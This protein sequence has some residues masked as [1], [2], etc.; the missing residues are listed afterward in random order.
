MLSLA[1]IALSLGAAAWIVDIGDS[2]P[3]ASAALPPANSLSFNER[4]TSLSG[5]QPARD[6]GLRPLER[7]ALNAVQ[8]KLRDARA[9]LAQ[10]L[11][12]GDWRSTLTD[13]DP[14]VADD[15]APSQRADAVPMPRSRPVQADLAA[16]V[17]SSQAYAETT[18]KVD[19]RSFFE[20]FTD[21]IKLASLTP[22]S[23]LFRKGPDL[24]ALGY[25]SRTAVYDISAKALYLPSGVTL[26]AHSGMGALMD[27]PDHVDQRMVGAT[28]PATYDLKPREKLFHGIRALRMTPAEGTTA[29]GRVGL[30]T[31]S[32]MLGPRGDSNG[33]VSI[34]D[35]DRFLKAYDNGEFNRLVVVPSLKGSA[36][37]S[38]RAT[39]DS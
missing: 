37:A 14:A 2:A 35:Y 13:D 24:A 23:G 3:L 15:P 29:L 32:Y 27:D 12:G 39:T 19:N 8:L 25:D 17:A 26:E 9:L 31:H 5:D 30:L 36:T 22:D 34:K 20:K 7:S 33:C 1:A 11:Q 18:P 10:Q 6:L 16:Q 21:K 38:Q 28:P 4:F